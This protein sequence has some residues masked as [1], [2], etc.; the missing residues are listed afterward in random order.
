MGD[1]FAGLVYMCANISLKKKII[2]PVRILYILFM[3]RWEYTQL[4]VCLCLYTG[5]LNISATYINVTLPIYAYTITIEKKSM[6][7]NSEYTSTRVHM[8]SYTCR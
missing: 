4:H 1:I 2:F 8:C 5:V 6:I 3:H 7:C